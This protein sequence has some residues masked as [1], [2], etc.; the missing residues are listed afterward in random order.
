M[1]TIEPAPVISR[2]IASDK[3]SVAYLSSRRYLASSWKIG[4][5][6]PR[7]RYDAARTWMPSNPFASHHVERAKYVSLV[8]LPYETGQ[9]HQA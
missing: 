5:C 1:K 2:T 8:M 9:E 6:L 4:E 3:G 7:R